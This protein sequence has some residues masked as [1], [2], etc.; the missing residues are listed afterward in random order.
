MR[1]H[2]TTVCA[3]FDAHTY[4]VQFNWTCKLIPTSSC[5]LRIIRYSKWCTLFKFLIIHK[6]VRDCTE[7]AVPLY[8][9]LGVLQLVNSYKLSQASYMKKCLCYYGTHSMASKLSETITFQSNI[10]YLRWLWC[11]ILYFDIFFSHYYSLVF[12]SWNSI[13]LFCI[14]KTL[15]FSP[16]SSV[17]F[18]VEIILICPWMNI[19]FSSSEW[20]W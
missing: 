1:L 12:M 6:N 19:K 5:L 11:L 18:F 16:T 17:A 20:S 15:F 8:C 13:P 4:Q 10:C 7:N 14:H 9:S 2:H 3:F